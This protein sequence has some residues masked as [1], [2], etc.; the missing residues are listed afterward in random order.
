M[1]H[2]GLCPHSSSQTVWAQTPSFLQEGVDEVSVPGTGVQL[3]GVAG[4]GPTDT[5]RGGSAGGGTGAAWKG[6]QWAPACSPDFSLGLLNKPVGLKKSRGSW[7]LELVKDCW[8]FCLRTT[9]TAECCTGWSGF[10]TGCSTPMTEDLY[11]LVA[12]IVLLNILLAHPN[13]PASFRVLHFW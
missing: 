13:V 7:Y 4:A 6:M 9:D 10:L 2:T 8:S 12:D 11:L 1:C 3:L 5:A